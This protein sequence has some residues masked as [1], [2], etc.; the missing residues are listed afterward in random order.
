MSMNSDPNTRNE[1]GLPLAW[2]APET[3][4]GGGALSGLTRWF[5]RMVCRYGS[6]DWW[7][8]A[9]PPARRWECVRCGVIVEE[10][11]TALPDR[12]RTPRDKTRPT[13]GPNLD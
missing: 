4:K 12:R 1:V 10:A 5:E 11:S 13:T 8:L 7:S 6:H 9:Y 3:P 2:P